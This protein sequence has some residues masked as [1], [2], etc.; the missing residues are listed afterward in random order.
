MSGI[1]IKEQ[2][3][4]SQKPLLIKKRVF[5]GLIIPGIIIISVTIFLRIHK[6]NEFT[7]ELNKRQSKIEE[8]QPG[9]I[10]AKNKDI[11]SIVAE[12]TKKDITKEDK[13]SNYGVIAAYYA[14]I[15][16][17]DK[18]IEYTLKIDENSGSDP[19]N[20]Y[21]YIGELYARKGD[22]PNALSSY[23]IAKTFADKINN[24]EKKNGVIEYINSRIK[25]LGV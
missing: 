22:K 7:S 4:D 11:D 6:S 14:D 25:E 9:F 21:M 3:K 15:E 16:D 12:N 8:K 10:E 13:N 18:A 17:Y 24:T 19:V 23:N 1:N 2:K 20:K 5:F